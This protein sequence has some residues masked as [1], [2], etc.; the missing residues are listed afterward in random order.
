MNL[1]DNQKIFIALIV[2]IF[3]MLIWIGGISG[4]IFIQGK[5]KENEKAPLFLESFRRMLQGEKESSRVNEIAIKREATKSQNSIKYDVEVTTITT[6]SISTSTRSIKVI[7]PNGGEKWIFGSTQTL[8]WT[9]SNISSTNAVKLGLRWHNNVDITQYSDF[10][11]AESTI[12]DGFETITS[13]PDIPFGIY[14][15]WVKTIVNKNS[16]SDFSDDLFNI[17]E[18]ETTETLPDLT[19]KSISASATSTAFAANICNKGNKSLK[20]FQITFS[21]NGRSKTLIDPHTLLPGFCTTI[22]SWGFGYYGISSGWSG[23]ITVS[24]DDDN[25]VRESNEVNNR[26]FVYTTVEF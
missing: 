4:V 10:I 11:L 14:S 21:A 6:S 9:S 22:Y 12:N 16:I 18:V 19:I 20:S 7:F 3:V 24:V 17:V 23:V 1:K 25:T 13:W 26:D 2:G 5:H 8:E 15:F